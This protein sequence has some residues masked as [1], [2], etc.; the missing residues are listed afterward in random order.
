[1]SNTVVHLPD[2]TPKLGTNSICPLQPLHTMTT[3]TPADE[4]FFHEPYNPLYTIV[5]TK[6]VIVNQ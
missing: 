5:P 4:Q 1:M 3:C 6:P 2:T